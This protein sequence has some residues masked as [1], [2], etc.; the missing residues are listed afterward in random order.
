MMKQTIWKYDVMINDSQKIEMPQGANLLSVQIQNGIPCIW[1]IVNPMNAEV[2]RVIQMA[3]T[4]HDMSERVMGAFLGT[5]QL[6][7]GALIFH[8]FDNGEE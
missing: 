4:G 6:N 2:E 1:A 8:V 7:D 5:I 3:G